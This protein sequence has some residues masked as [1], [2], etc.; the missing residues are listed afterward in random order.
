MLTEIWGQGRLELVEE[1]YAPDD[2]DHVA[3]G[4]E[5]QQVGLLRQLGVVPPDV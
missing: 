4:P 5:P 2:I 1:L 3:A